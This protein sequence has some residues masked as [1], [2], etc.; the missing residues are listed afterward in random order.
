MGPIL[1]KIG[2]S[3]TTFRAEAEYDTPEGCFGKRIL[4][5]LH[6]PFFSQFKNTPRASQWDN[7]R[8]KLQLSKEP[9]EVI[10]AIRGQPIRNPPQSFALVLKFPD[11]TS[12]HL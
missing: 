2:A 3:E 4:C 10:T 8:K 1:T 7:E 9:K 6:F 11:K 5:I 12:E